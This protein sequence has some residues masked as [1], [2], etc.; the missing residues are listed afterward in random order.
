MSATTSIAELVER[1]ERE[2]S[3]GLE[4]SAAEYAFV[5]AQRLREDGRFP[6]LAI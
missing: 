4:R 1:F 6:E 2:R 3:R 5:L